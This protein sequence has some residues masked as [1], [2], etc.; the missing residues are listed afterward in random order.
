[1]KHDNFRY[2]MLLKGLQLMAVGICTGLF[3]GV[4]VTFYNI[5]ASFIT[6]Y[7]KDLY[8]G[9]LEQPYF[10][11]LLF[12][13]LA[14]SGFAVAVLVHFIPMIRGSGIPQTEGA[15]RGLLNFKWYQVLPA[16]AAASLYCMFLGLSAGS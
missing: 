1:M 3:A 11:P 12:L 4:V 13:V 7:A 8:R 2:K 5:A 15:S 9:I 6:S 16:M 10:I 14:I